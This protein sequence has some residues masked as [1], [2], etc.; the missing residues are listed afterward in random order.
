MDFISG[1]IIVGMAFVIAVLFFFGVAVWLTIGPQKNRRYAR[2]HA[3]SRRAYRFN[4][5]RMTEA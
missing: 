3:R 4:N 2:Q 1:V 5:A